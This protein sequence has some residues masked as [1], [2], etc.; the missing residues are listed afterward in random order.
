MTTNPARERVINLIRQLQTKTTANGC[1]EAEAL[2]A[3]RKINELLERYQLAVEDVSEIRDDVYGALKR[4]Y[5]GGTWRRRT[6]HE[7]KTAWGG[8]AAFTDTKHWTSGADLVFF[9]SKTDCELAF[10]LVDLIRATGESEWQAFRGRGEGRTDRRGRA[11]FLAGFSI[12][13]Y[14]RLHELARQRRRNVTSTGRDLVVVKDQVVAQKFQSY[15]VKSGLKLVNRS[16]SSSRRDAECYRAGE[17]AGSRVNL[18][19]GVG[20]RSASAGRIGR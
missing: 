9:G 14:N 7:T 6:W 17:A 8:I 11:S 1:T 13:I 20:G 2:E 3:A 5:G 16:S 19:T 15:C 18:T 12:R 10:Y 4:Q